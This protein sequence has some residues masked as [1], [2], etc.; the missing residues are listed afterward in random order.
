ML[1][2][3]QDATR[4]RSGAGQRRK[5]TGA[6][7]STVET[8]NAFDVLR[9]FSDEGRQF[10]TVVIDPPGLAKRKEGLATARR[11]YH[12]LNLRAMKLVRP[13]GVLVSCS[14]SGKLSRAAFEE[15]LLGAAADAKR[16]VQV[17]ERRGAGI[18][19]P[20]SLACPTRSTSRRGFF[21]RCDE[22]GCAGGAHH[23]V[24]CRA[25]ARG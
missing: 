2:V 18:D 12:E 10:D 6:A 1:A 3:E 4:R 23:G 24:G 11:A 8:G 22:L 14:C 15:M 5:P 21:G 7:T 16:Q 20:C 9:R 17:L 13:D 25:N 19:H